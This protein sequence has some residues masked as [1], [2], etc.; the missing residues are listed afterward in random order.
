MYEKYMKMCFKLA[1]R[2]D[3][4][5]SPN[6]MVGAILIDEDGKVLSKGYHKAYGQCHAEVDCINNFEKK[7]PDA[8]YSNLTLVV[9][10]EPCNHYGKTPPCSDLILN[11]GIKKVVIAVKDPDNE[12][13]GGIEK[14]EKNGIEVIKNVL[15]DEAKKLN[16]VFFKNVEEKMP[17]V[18][19]KTATTLDG[20]I[21]TK[22]GSSKW[23][24]SSLARDYVQKLRNRYDAILT[25]A[26]TVMIDNPSL[27]ARGKGLKNPVRIILDKDLKTD[28]ISKVYNADGVKVFIFHCCDNKK[29]YPKNVELIKVDKTKE[30]H[31]NL[32]SILKILFEKRICSVLIEAGGELNG[33]FLKEN[34]VDKIYQFVA[35]KILGDTTGKS[36]VEG[37]D[38]NDIN[39]CYQTKI[40]SVKKF[41]P[42]ILIE[43]D[44]LK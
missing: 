42:D 1:M 27:T 4:K 33:A 21:A 16:E 22:T 8:D 36:F 24:T 26:K 9:N 34:L 7:N 13:S 20:K 3:G 32:K 43:T 29:Q 44:L 2:G 14:L 28:A 11:K 40:S 19:I 30:N 39:E 12:H 35:P 31:L 6:P 5:T 41:A 18:V 17:F 25:S 38:I 37:F 15:E 23:I 10:L